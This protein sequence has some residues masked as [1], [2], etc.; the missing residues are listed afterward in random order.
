VHARADSCAADV[1]AVGVLIQTVHGDRSKAKT[2]YERCLGIDPHHENARRNLDIL[3]REMGESFV[4]IGDG[5][6]DLTLSDGAHKN[7]NGT[8]MAS[9]SSGSANK[10]G[11]NMVADSSQ[12]PANIGAD[13]A[14]NGSAPVMGTHA[15]PWM[16]DSSAVP[17][18]AHESGGQGS[19]VQWQGPGAGGLPT[20]VNVDQGLQTPVGNADADR[21]GN[22]QLGDGI[23]VTTQPRVL[24]A[25]TDSV[26][27]QG[28]H[29]G[30]PGATSTGFAGVS[31]P[32]A[33]PGSGQGTP[34]GAPG[35]AGSGSG[36]YSLPSYM[37][38]AAA[39]A[40]PKPKVP[41]NETTSFVGM[42]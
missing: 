40:K 23:T 37:G 29:E 12:L 5:L 20:Q 10:G 21:R 32:M 3:L 2:Y 28:D 33:S 34:L 13:Y 19:L 8:L 26:P 9:S 41:Y 1:V 4:D 38:S 31:T 6:E 18:H 22:P 25:R 30:S 42:C 39:K 11:I 17:Y 36:T 27:M 15:G 16:S 14:L 24:A 7:D 35:S